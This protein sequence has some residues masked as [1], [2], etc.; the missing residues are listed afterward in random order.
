LD[1]PC[2]L[3]DIEKKRFLSKTDLVVEI[4]LKNGKPRADM[5]GQ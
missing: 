5:V 1:I 4:R 3:L 2:W